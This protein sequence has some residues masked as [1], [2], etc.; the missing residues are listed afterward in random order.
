[1]V[2]RRTKI[3]VTYGPALSELSRLERVMEAGADVFR[4]NCSH[5]GGSQLADAIARVQAAA[6][7][8]G[9]SPAL[10]LD[11]RGAEIRIGS[12]PEAG[13]PLEQGDEIVLYCC[14]EPAENDGQANT[15]ILVDYPDL[16]KEIQPDSRIL[17]GDGDIILHVN[18][19]RTDELICRVENGGVLYGK[20]KVTV[21][22]LET[23]LP[24]LTDADIEDVRLGVELG[25][26]F[27]AASFVREA[28]QVHEVR[29]IVEEAGGKAGIIAKIETRQAVENFAE[30]LAASD[31]IMVARGDLGLEFPSED[32]PFLQ[33]SIIERSNRAGK[34]VIT[35]TQMLESMTSQPR[36]TRAESADV[37]NAILDGT[38]AVMLSGETAIGKYPVETV[39]TMA[40]IAERADAHIQERNSE[41]GVAWEQANAQPDT[42]EVIGRATCQAAKALGASAII[43]PTSSGY[44]PRMI[45]R[46]R[47]AV[48][49]IA[50]TTNPDVAPKLSLVWGVHTLIS[51]LDKPD[52]RVIDNAIAEALR[53]E[54]VQQGDLVIVT[55]GFPAGVPGAT[56]MM[57]VET[58][59][60]PFLHATGIGDGWATGRPVVI[61]DPE[62]ARH[63]RPGD[64]LVVQG[65]RSEV[66]EMLKT[67]SAVIA[68]EDGLTCDTAIAGLSLGI[69]TIVGAKG[70]LAALRGQKV[71]TVDAKRGIVYL[72]R[73]TI[74]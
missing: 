40:R 36:P 50:V 5:G 34:P 45:A 18:D 59:A 48:P 63:W 74:R 10:L 32:V 29:K 24:A 9:K 31:G 53:A 64:I 15:R 17:L 68:E 30:I 43:V 8:I 16:A 42:T 60:K 62:D 67:A 3:V 49:I 6:E 46:H 55:G 35:A 54:L 73:A 14:D 66:Q 71:I 2:G 1:M 44:T 57:L 70:A 58:V 4:F 23:S 20:R 26:T 37:A 52:E 19:V 25:V 61:E 33:K 69:P 47:P 65:A 41:T 38:D 13:V 12:L 72:G 21:P 22:G 51:G 56:N 39:K 7:R 28:R 27:V 11:T